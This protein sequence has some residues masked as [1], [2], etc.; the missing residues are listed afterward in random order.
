MRD[1]PMPMVWHG[2]INVNCGNCTRKSNC[3][4]R[5][6]IIDNSKRV[7]LI[8]ER[9]ICS[10]HALDALKVPHN[11]NEK[12]FKLSLLLSG[13]GSGHV[14]S[15]KSMADIIKITGG[16]V[17]FSDCKIPI[18]SESYKCEN[19]RYQ[20]SCQYKYTFKNFNRTLVFKRYCAFIS[21]LVNKLVCHCCFYVTCNKYM[22][23]E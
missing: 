20:N 13:E 23:K 21:L 14:I 12:I 6:F 5:K 9:E 10:F 4:S 17:V 2:N 7:E 11:S 19:C 16:R 3:K 15:I 1:C 22:A 8:A 18:Y